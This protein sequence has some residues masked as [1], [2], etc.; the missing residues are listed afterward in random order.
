MFNIISRS[1]K[2]VLIFVQLEKPEIAKIKFEL[3]ND[4]IFPGKFI[5]LE[6]KFKVQKYKFGVLYVK[7][8]QSKE[9]ELYSN[10]II[11]N[12]KF[13]TFKLKLHLNLKNFSISW[14]LE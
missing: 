2:E 11:F 3:K 12:L 13:L 6:E 1:P 5:Q 10:G 4:P 8:G 7:K 9:N 14:E